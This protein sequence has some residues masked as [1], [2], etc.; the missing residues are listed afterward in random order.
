MQL[1]NPKRDCTDYQRRIDMA[2]FEQIEQQESKKN[3]N[4]NLNLLDESKVAGDSNNSGKIREPKE[5]EQ[6]EP[7]K[8][9][10][11]GSDAQKEQ[12]PP[13]KEPDTGAPKGGFKAPE[14]LPVPE[15]AY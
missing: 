7:K 8:D 15:D 10:D 3:E 6:V 11:P 4:T 2:N 9:A 13:T 12:I 1:L 5:R 14:T